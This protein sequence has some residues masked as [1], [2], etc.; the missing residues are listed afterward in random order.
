M[1]GNATRLYEGTSARITDT[2]CLNAFT[3][4]WREAGA[5]GLDWS[6]SEETELLKATAEVLTIHLLHTAA[7]KERPSPDDQSA[8]IAELALAIYQAAC[9]D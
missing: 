2:E 5:E 7:S 8:S 9:L 4:A 1:V 6:G 3:S